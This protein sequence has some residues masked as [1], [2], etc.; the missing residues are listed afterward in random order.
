MAGEYSMEN[1]I[2]AQHRRQAILDWLH[3]HPLSPMG[4]IAGAFPCDDPFQVICAVASMVRR[5][6][7]AA[8]GKRKSSLFVALATTT[9]TAESLKAGKRERSRKASARVRQRR[10]SE[11]VRQP[12][13]EHSTTPKVGPNG[14]RLYNSGDNPEIARYRSGGQGTV[15]RPAI[16][17]GMYA[18]GNW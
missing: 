11:K 7:I 13:A 3:A 17:S 6:E 18:G 10:S 15:V 2:Q 4:R 1:L 8:T 16:G 9:A 12:K 14:G 5:G